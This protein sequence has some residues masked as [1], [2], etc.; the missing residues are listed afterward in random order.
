MTNQQIINHFTNAYTRDINTKG[1]KPLSVLGRKLYSYNVC[2]AEYVVEEGFSGFL[3]HDH[4]AKGL[5]A[6]SSTTSQHVG[7]IIRAT[8]YM[9]RR[10][11]SEQGTIFK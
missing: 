1:N 9:P 8:Q 2:I 3:I 6:I 10:L 5:G 7:M 4:W 11:Q